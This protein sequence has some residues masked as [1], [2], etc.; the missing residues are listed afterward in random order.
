MGQRSVRRNSL[1][2]LHDFYGRSSRLAP[3]EGS[4]MEVEAGCGGV[5]G[6]SGADEGAPQKDD[7][8]RE[9][10]PVVVVGAEFGCGVCLVLPAGGV[11]HRFFRQALHTSLPVLSPRELASCEE[12]RRRDDLGILQQ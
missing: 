12:L 1:S 11:S 8:D 9:I 5:S 3:T 10:A 2:S 4:E 7:A 6:F